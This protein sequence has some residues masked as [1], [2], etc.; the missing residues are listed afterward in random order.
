MKATLQVAVPES[1]LLIIL[2]GT[3]RTGLLILRNALKQWIVRKQ[4]R[5]VNQTE[6]SQTHN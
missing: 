5:C 2:S 1:N 6:C 3:W 4:D